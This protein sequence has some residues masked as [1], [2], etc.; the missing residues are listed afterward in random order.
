MDDYFHANQNLWNEYARAHVGSEF[1]GVDSFKQGATSLHPLEMDELGDVRERSLLHLQCHFGLDTL[2]WA[3]QGAQVTRVDF[4]DQAVTL[5]RNLSQECRIPARFICCNIYDLPHH[6]GEQFDIVFTSYGA[7]TWLPD[8]SRWAQIVSHF[9]KPGGTFYIV[10]FH[11]FA[12]IFDEQSAGLQVRDPYFLDGAFEC[13]EGGGT[14]ADPQAKIKQPVSYEWSYPLGNVVS[15]LI[16][17]GLQIQFLHEFPFTVY[18]QLSFMVK[19]SDGYWWMPDKAK[20]LPL[21]FSI[22]ATKVI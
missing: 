15:S 22:R 20:T 9:L 14:Y 18:Q 4:S 2:S 10:E 6:L 13:L 17:A 1:Y 21:L 3:R 11:P 12:L 7:L 16:S 19:D 8:I 5:A